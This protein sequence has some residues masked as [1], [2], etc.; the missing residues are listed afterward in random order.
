M[1]N[2]LSSPTGKENL[3]KTSLLG[4]NSE[5]HRLVTSRNSGSP[6]KPVNSLLTE[7]TNPTLPK[8]S[9]TLHKKLTK[10]RTYLLTP[11]LV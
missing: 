9:E 8:N 10:L 3:S 2:H 1:E 5:G 6:V 11:S 7:T 4:L